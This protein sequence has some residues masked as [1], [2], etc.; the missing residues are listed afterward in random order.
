MSIRVQ[1]P[2]GQTA[3]FPDGTPTAE[4]ERALSDLHGSQGPT[5]EERYQSAGIDPHEYAA[6]DDTPEWQKRAAGVGHAFARMGQAVHQLGAHVLDSGSPDTKALDESIALDDRTWNS[7]L[8]KPGT[9]T[10]PNPYNV[11]GN[12]ATLAAT[13]PLGAVGAAGKGVSLASAALRGAGTSTAIGALTNPVVDGGEDFW[14][15][16]G[17]AAAIDAGL[18][19]AGQVIPRA[20]AAGGRQALD[21]TT[22]ALAA[23]AE[24]FG[25]QLPT[26]ALTD[27]K[28]VKLVSSVLDKLPFSGAGARTKAQQTGLNQAVASTI[29]ETAD[30]ITPEVAQ[31]ARSR[32][33]RTFEDLTGRND[34]TL[35]NDAL[36]RL[37]DIAHEA[38]QIGT[39]DV[40]RAVESI[41]DEALSKSNNGVIAGKAYQALDRKL[42]RTVAMTSDGEKRHYF[43]QVREALRDAMDGSISE[44]DSAAW[45]TAREQWWALKTIEPLIEKAPTGNISPSLLLGAVRAN[46]TH[47]A[48]GS[49]G[50]LADLGRIGQ[51]FL[52][53]TV[54]D[55][56][57]ASRLLV[58]DSLKAAAG[59]GVG[60]A[61]GVS[62]P[63]VAGT[64]ALGRGANALLNSRAARAYMQNGLGDAAQPIAA[65]LGNAAPV[66]APML[67]GQRARP[68][69]KTA[70]EKGHQAAEDAIGSAKSRQETESQLGM[71]ERGADRYEK[72]AQRAMTPEDSMRLAV[73]AQELRDQA[74]AV[75]AALGR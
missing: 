73:R 7:D 3:E 62:L 52:K 16:K 19:A 68:A 64:L 74:D 29:G 67:D 26:A 13:A 10:A 33:N 51:Q 65:A 15:S 11:I 34:L 21:A 66:A 4:M 25:I 47:M 5:L 56:G 27:S 49:G 72:A 24:Q 57:T 2:N 61:T 31:A 70:H 44:A 41:T 32:L 58:Q 48:Y 71:L 39:S 43:G 40:A 54:P 6:S 46:T 53:D 9:W 20:V 23:K 14:T 63:A 22:K 69:P 1:L 35:D 17:K 30:R 50:K 55:S 18:G 8:G 60:T 37:S 36:Q 42:G 45:Q 38:K 59:A 12:V 28:A 75:R